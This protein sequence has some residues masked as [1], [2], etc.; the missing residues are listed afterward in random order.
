MIL[1]IYIIIHTL[2]SLI[3]IFVIGGALALLSIVFLMPHMETI[4]SLVVLVACAVAIAGRAQ[5]TAETALPNYYT[6]LFEHEACR[7]H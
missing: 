2:V 3:A 6:W 5:I 7:N 4:V 1:H